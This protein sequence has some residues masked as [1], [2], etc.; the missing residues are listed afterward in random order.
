MRPCSPPTRVREFVRG[1]GSVLRE[2]GVRVRRELEA[3]LG[4]RVFLEMRVNVERDW[5]VRP[6]V[7]RRLGL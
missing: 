3:C 7:M 1:G 6:E 2:V 5:Q 4:R